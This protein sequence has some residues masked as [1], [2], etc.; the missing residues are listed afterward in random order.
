MT[1]W[2]NETGRNYVEDRPGSGEPCPDP[3]PGPVCLCPDV[4]HLTFRNGEEVQRGS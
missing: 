1:L 4:V 3:Y 2:H